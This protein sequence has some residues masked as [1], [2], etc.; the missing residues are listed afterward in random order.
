[1]LIWK[2]LA[3]R[4][5]SRGWVD[6]YRPPRVLSADIRASA[7]STTASTTRMTSGGVNTTLVGFR[8]ATSWWYSCCRLGLGYPT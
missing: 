2:P 8:T 5:Q 6:G 3:N 7:A 1:M 4:K